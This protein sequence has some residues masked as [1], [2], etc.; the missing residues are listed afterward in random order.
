[1]PTSFACNLEI[2]KFKNKVMSLTEGYNAILAPAPQFE[3]NLKHF[4][5][6]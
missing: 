1:M 2:I 4:T 5:E 3:K 6:I